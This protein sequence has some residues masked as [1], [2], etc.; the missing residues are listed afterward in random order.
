MFTATFFKIW[1]HLETNEKSSEGEWINTWGTS[2][3]WTIFSI[4]KK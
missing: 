4:K 2:G 1:E 3:Q